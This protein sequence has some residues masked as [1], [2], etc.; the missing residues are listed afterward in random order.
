MDEYLPFG[1]TDGDLLVYT[2]N[3]KYDRTYFY[4]YNRNNFV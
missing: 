1:S 2:S 4:Y 3:Q